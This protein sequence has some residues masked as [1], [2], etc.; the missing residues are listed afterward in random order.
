VGATGIGDHVSGSKMVTVWLLFRVDT[1]N[2]P[3]STQV[4]SLYGEAIFC[5]YVLSFLPT[6]MK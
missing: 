1:F 3:S 5:M 6:E 4:G 2:V